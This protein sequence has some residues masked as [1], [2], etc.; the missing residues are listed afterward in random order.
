MTGR[1]RIH[2]P[3]HGVQTVRAEHHAMRPVR[4]LTP[5]I[6]RAGKE[7]ARFVTV[8]RKRGA[9]GRSR[10]VAGCRPQQQRSTA[11]AAVKAA[12]AVNRAAAHP[13]PSIEATR[14]V[15]AAGVGA[16]RRCLELDLDGVEGKA[17]NDVGR[18]SGAAASILAQPGRC[19]WRPGWSVA[20]PYLSALEGHD[21][22]LASLTCL[23]S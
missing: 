6:M 18:A 3:V 9:R 17:N 15:E 10:R 7:G 13:T 23:R 16:M 5:H 20:A 1:R 21:G 22:K 8:A 19:R 11:A 12:A 14:A 2:G 4:E